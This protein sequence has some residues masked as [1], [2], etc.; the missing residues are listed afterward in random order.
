MVPSISIIMPVYNTDK[1]YLKKAI[2]SVIN[3]SYAWFEFIIIDDCSNDVYEYILK[4]YNDKRIRLYKNE[5]N[6][7]VAKTL[8]KGLELARGDFIARMDSDDIAHK[9]RISKQLIFLKKNPSID[10]LGSSVI[11]IGK[12]SGIK[13]FPRSSDEIRA[14]LFF[15]SPFVHPAIMFRANKFNE[16]N[17]KYDSDYSSEDFELWTRCAQIKDFN[18]YNHPKALLKYRVHTKQVTSQSKKNIRDHSDVIRENYIRSF[19]LNFN[20]DEMK[21]FNSFSSGEEN[22]FFDDFVKIDKLLLRLIENNKQSKNIDTKSLEKVFT[23]KLFKEYLRKLK[24]LRVSVKSYKHSKV[25]KNNMIYYYIL[26]I[27]SSICFR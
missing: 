13:R 16:Y 11:F 27:G 26:K 15:G 22:L 5:K 10:L 4:N 3:Q 7:G 21:L 9:K 19:G 20:E 6:L 1:K 2:D 17:I 12:K 25:I 23:N 14:S 24:L 18:F 8:N